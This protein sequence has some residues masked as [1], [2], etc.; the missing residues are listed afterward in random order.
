MKDMQFFSTVDES[1]RKEVTIEGIDKFKYPKGHK[2]EGINIEWI[3]QPLTMKKLDEIYAENTVIKRKGGKT[4]KVINEKR[5]GYD[6]MVESIVYPD[7]KDKNWL[8][9]N[10]MVDPVELIKK[11]LDLPKDFQ[12]IS[13]EV[14]CING[15][16]DEEEDLIKEAKN[17]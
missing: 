8:E 14:M 7:F 2:K 5:M 11:V 4:S 10:K 13:E 6:L 9:Q 1:E 17:L 15:F 16:G 12:R 3:V